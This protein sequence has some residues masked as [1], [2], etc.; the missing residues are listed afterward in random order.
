MPETRF[1]RAKHVFV[2]K[3]LALTSREAEGSRHWRPRQKRILMVE[4]HLHY[5][6]PCKKLS[7][8]MRSKPPRQNFLFRLRACK[9]RHLPERCQRDLGLGSARS[10]PSWITFWNKDPNHFGHRH[11]AHSGIGKEDIA[12]LTV[13]YPDQMIVAHPHQ[14]AGARQDSADSDRGHPNGWS[15]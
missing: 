9:S 15:L 11:P 12:Y 10:F 4:P 1:W 7:S 14:L 5:S 13:R 8:L 6:P 2:E 3:P